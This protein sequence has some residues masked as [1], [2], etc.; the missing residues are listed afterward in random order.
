MSAIDEAVASSRYFVVFC[1]VLGFEL[2]LRGAQA[3]LLA[4]QRLL[5][6]GYGTIWNAWDQ[7]PVG[8]M[9]DKGPTRYEL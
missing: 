9:H 3:I 4:A 5:L 7:T 1:F 2:H 6:E 8:S